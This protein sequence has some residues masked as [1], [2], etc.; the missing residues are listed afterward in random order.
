[1][2]GSVRAGLTKRLLF[3]S[4]VI[5]VLSFLWFNADL[6]G[7]LDRNSEHVEIFK[8]PQDAALGSLDIEKFNETA[9]AISTPMK[10]DPFEDELRRLAS[11]SSGEPSA[12]LARGLLQTPTAVPSPTI[13]STSNE[14]QRAPRLDPDDGRS[15]FS[16]L[17]QDQ[18]SR[19][20]APLGGV[21]IRSPRGALPVVT[22]ELTPNGRAWVG[23]QARGYTMLYAM[24]P[25]ARP[26]VEANVQALLGA[27]VREPYIGV[28]IDGT[29]GRDFGYLKDII[30][31]L[32]AEDRA[33]AL[34]LYLSNG[35]TMRK[36][37]IT[38][39]DQHIFARLSPD[40]FRL[41]IRRNMT[42]RAE[43]LAVVLQ[44]K[45]VFTHNL[46]LGS[47]NSNS[48][49]VML[50]DNLDVFAYRALRE[51]AA[52]QLG[53]ISGFMRN[54]CVGCFEGND[55]DTLGDAREEHQ[56][57]RFEILK[58]GDAY[59]LDGVG[60]RYPDG[61]GSGV[62]PEQLINFIKESMRR[63]LRLFGLWQ[64]AWQGVKEGV[65][66]KRPEERIYLPS[67]PDQQL[68]EIEMLRTG[69]IAEEQQ[70]SADNFISMP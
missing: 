65:L 47:G 38:P 17:Q 59:S 5:G 37:E 60:F 54:P 32:S 2:S 51:I 6:L 27:R 31:R 52:E 29:F 10:R 23:G 50:E 1:M 56:I 14:E 68:F 55:D 57:N 48:A 40:E 24:Q 9:T 53:P 3:Y 70:P 36:W 15:L 35:P 26:V 18:G 46:S 69:L 8:P 62:S 13:L 33:L 12:D 61:S 43:F 45:D 39:I 42:L 44:A 20:E 34:V 7:V 22:P 66:N 25:E 63:D 11:E 64:E 16:E 30:T 58:S 21:V 4:L 41:Q 49:I 19:V 28:L 67:S